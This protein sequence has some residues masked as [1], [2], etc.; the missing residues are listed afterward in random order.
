MIAENAMYLFVLSFALYG[1]LLVPYYCS[2]VL[3]RSN[4]EEKTWFIIFVL[5]NVYALIYT[6]TRKTYRKR[7][8]MKSRNVFMAFILGYIGFL[9]AIFHI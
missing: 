1:I 8:S 6:L 3:A 2:K 4:N 5:F 9:A 7:M